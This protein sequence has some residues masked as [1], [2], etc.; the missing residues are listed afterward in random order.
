MESPYPKL[1]NYTVLIN[2]PINFT[3]IMYI[4]GGTDGVCI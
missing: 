4:E 3:N 2:K 1:S